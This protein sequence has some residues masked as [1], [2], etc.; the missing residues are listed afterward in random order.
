METINNNMN[1]LHL[2]NESTMQKKEENMT[3]TP[4]PFMQAG[5]PAPPSLSFPN[6]PTLPKKSLT[7]DKTT[8][9]GKHLKVRDWGR[10]GD[11]G[12][13]GFNRGFYYQAYLPFE[14]NVTLEELRSKHQ[15]L[16]ANMQPGHVG[17][18]EIP[19][20]LGAGQMMYNQGIPTTMMTAPIMTSTPFLAS[21]VM[22]TTGVPFQ[23][24]NAPL[25]GQ[26][27]TMYNTNAPFMTAGPFVPGTSYKKSKHLRKAYKTSSV[28]VAPT[29]SNMISVV[30]LQQVPLTHT[31]SF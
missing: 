18:R 29:Y 3:K 15:P 2:N 9:G 22:I 13:S 24:I 6:P 31:T 11:E 25:G 26:Y 4:F 20:S 10:V 5:G 17:T 30:P 23:S 21:P 14:R 16:L 1:N 19:S 7:Q 12:F 28:P 8:F 27:T